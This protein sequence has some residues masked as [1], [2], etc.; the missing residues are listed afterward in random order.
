[1]KTTE[2]ILR[3]AIA[4]FRAMTEKECRERMRAAVE[5]ARS[6]RLPRRK[7]STR[8][9]PTVYRCQGALIGLRVC[10]R[11][12]KQLRVLCLRLWLQDLLIAWR[13]K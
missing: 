6:A 4:D 8:S 9:A 13:R 10:P 11:T 12:G 3:G 5:C 2:D 1:M 7:H